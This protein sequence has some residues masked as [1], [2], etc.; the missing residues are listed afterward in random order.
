MNLTDQ[1]T[2]LYRDGPGDSQT[3]YEGIHEYAKTGLLAHIANLVAARAKPGASV[4]DLACGAGALALRLSHA[5][6]DVHA[7][8]YVPE[9]FK[10]SLPFTQ[11]DLNE[12]FSSLFPKFDC[13]VASEIIEH[14]ENPR[15]FLREL[16]KMLNPGGFVV[17]TTPNPDSPV[18]HA[19]LLA[20]GHHSWFSD[21]DYKTLGHITPVSARMLRQAAAEVG[22]SIEVDSWSDAWENVRGWPKMQLYAW[23]V[24]LL[25]RSPLKGDI[26]EAILRSTR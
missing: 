6:V 11:A 21:D 17:L 26:L 9:N 22:L 20:L 12:D 5:G 3:T 2:Q 14:L 15:H 10:V 18:S 25:D 4:L 8:D 24:S 13:I 23:L 16:A 19:L 1:R 7:C